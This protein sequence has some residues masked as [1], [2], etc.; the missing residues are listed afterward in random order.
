MYLFNKN[1]RRLLVYFAVFY[2]LLFIFCHFNSARD[3]GSYFFR[4]EEGYRPQYSVRRILES[5]HFISRFN[6]STPQPKQSLQNVT[7]GGRDPTICAGIVT[8]KRP[9]QQNL[10]T[11]VG[12]LL[13]GLSRE[14]RANIVVHVLF[15]LSNP[16]DHPDYPQP[17]ASNV[18]DRI[19]TYKNSGADVSQMERWERENMIKD[20]SHEKSGDNQALEV[21][22]EDQGLAIPA[23]LLHRKI[24]RLEYG[25]MAHLSYLKPCGYLTRGTGRC[26]CAATF[27]AYARDIDEP[28]PC[29]S[30]SAVCSFTYRLIFPGR[31]CDSA[32][33]AARR[34]SHEQPRMLLT[35]TSI[36][37]RESALADGPFRETAKD[38]TRACGQCH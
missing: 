15:A 5:R 12:S 25:G 6:Q 13:D 37:S 9:I 35:S 8:V 3:P 10:D 36:S 28:L 26:L 23:S 2:V 29:G 16:Y 32:A 14:Q 24:P 19:L 7:S 11:A 21:A 33:H 30:L 17:W 18:I 38:K 1:Q 22:R 4:P 31:P 20:K 27:T 34:P